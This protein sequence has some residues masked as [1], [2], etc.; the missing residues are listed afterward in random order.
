MIYG[1][2]TV[3]TWNDGLDEDEAEPKMGQR[4]N[5]ELRPERRLYEGAGARG[6]GGVAGGAAGG[7]GQGPRTRWSRR[8]RGYDDDDE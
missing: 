3:H 8:R 1:T 6:N 4:V 7:A 2:C 5:A